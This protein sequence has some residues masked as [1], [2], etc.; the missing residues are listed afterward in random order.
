MLTSDELAELAQITDRGARKAIQSRRWRGADLI[1]REE[2][3]NVGRGGKILK[4]HVDSLPKDLRDDWYLQHGIDPNAKYEPAIP[5]EASA[6]EA[7]FKQSKKFE[8]DLQLARWRHDVIRPAL[9]CR[10]QSPER[11]AIFDELAGVERLLPNGTRKR[12]SRP[13]L[14]RWVRAFEENNAG[15]AGL[16]PKE[17]S[18]KGKRDVTVS[19]TWDGFFA[20]HVSVEDHARV[21]DD[22][23]YYIR[24]LWGSGERGKYAVSE[25]A[26][27][28]LIEIS[29]DLNVV[30]F[31]ALELGRPTTKSGISTQ[32]EVCFVNTRQ[33][34]EERKYGLWAIK[35][36]DNAKFQD[37]YVPHIRRDYSAYNPRDIIVGDVHP[38]DVMMRRADGSVVY[39][40]AIS[41]MDIATNEMHM[42][43]VLCEPGEGIKRE[44][45]AMSF[46]AMVKAWG[47]P[48]LLYLDNGSEYKWHEMIGGFT[49]L[50]KLV[51]EGGGTFGLH[52]LG[53]NAEVADRVTRS[54]EA[55]IRSLAYNAKGKPKIEGAFGNIEKVQFAL[56]PG[57]TAGDRMSKKTHAKG[58]D[59][60][61]YPG[62]PN[63][64][65][66]D[67]S[68]MLEWY[69]KRPQRGRLDGR[70]PNE[71]LRDFIEGGWGKTVMKDDKVL[72]LAFS[73]EVT[74]VPK[75]GRVSFK[76]RH[77][78]TTY[79]YHDKLLHFKEAITLRVP[80]Y[81]PEFVFCFNGEK[82]I[83]VA[84]PEQSF[85]VLDRAGAEELGR[86]KKYFHREITEMAK[87]CALLDLVDETKRHNAHMADAP[88]APVA[89]TVDAGM[90]D[91]MA[92]IASEEREAMLT[93]HAEKPKPKGPASQWKTGPNKVLAGF[94]FA[95]DEDE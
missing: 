13:Q 3:S 74:R 21:A 39:P 17:N 62:T 57:W 86:R 34:T 9:E 40:K 75:S 20:D 58:K 84:K 37:E 80:A 44:H 92:E 10:K 79:Y 43:F 87:H 16:M 70:S 38:V 68:G 50:S 28:R 51:E 41:W 19:R 52:D 77:G 61:A 55:V 2:A 76:T 8:A 95:E 82:L 32:F 66:A 31:D 29:R 83:C 65:L 56:L 14:Y 11:S 46:E 1:V 71:V 85:G 88:E 49:Q 36:K 53:D 25:K 60:I 18:R 78:E 90:L 89:V 63:E 72:A 47:L 45:V 23:T 24:S 93:E 94:Q 6:F 81:K 7:E 15:L 64:F 30:A 35:R 91:R 54:R 22:L 73:D 59:P 27:T 67:A 12:I 5:G 48:K 33:V 4:V 69:H 42:T 26:T